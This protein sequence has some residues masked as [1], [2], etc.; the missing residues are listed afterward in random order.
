MRA[1]G[2]L[3]LFFFACIARTEKS[4]RKSVSNISVVEQQKGQVSL[5][6]LSV[7]F[8]SSFYRSSLP[9]IRLLK[10][11][12]IFWARMSAHRDRGLKRMRE[13]KK[14]NNFHLTV[15]DRPIF[16]GVSRSFLSMD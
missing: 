13:R 11:L 1:F 14:P 10:K 7:A 9:L 15:H 16:D 2:A 12:S 4:Y 6:N 5:S 8:W 3:Y